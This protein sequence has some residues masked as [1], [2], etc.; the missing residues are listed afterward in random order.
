M[1][2]HSI[3]SSLLIRLRLSQGISIIRDEW[4]LVRIFVPDVVG[5]LAGYQTRTLGRF[6]YYGCTEARHVEERLAPGLDRLGI[7]HI[8]N[9][10]K[11][12]AL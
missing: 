2:F 8:H 9:R 11:Q 6:N 12:T 3:A 7:V 4:E 5:H 1:H 10:H